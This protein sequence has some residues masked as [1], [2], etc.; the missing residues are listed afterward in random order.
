[1]ELGE[2]WLCIYSGKLI[3]VIDDFEWSVKR[4]SFSFFE[5][6]YGCDGLFA[7]K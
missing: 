5:G 7:D 2:S 4:V 1:M 6:E 3:V